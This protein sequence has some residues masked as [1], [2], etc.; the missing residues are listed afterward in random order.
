M[1]PLL[2][3]RSFS[4]YILP[5]LPFRRRQSSTASTP[6]LSNSPTSP[7]SASPPSPSY[8]H[9]ATNTIQC[10]RCRAD[11]A[12]TSQII[13]KGFTGRHGRA[14]LVAPPART[15]PFA[16]AP[17]A[18]ATD[19]PPGLPNTYEHRAVPRSLV[20]GA[21]V[22]S[23]IACARCH[24][25]LGWRYVAAEEPAQRYKVG[26]YIVETKRTTVGACWDRPAEK[27]GEVWGGEDDGSCGGGDEE[28]AFDSQDEEECDALFAGE[29]SGE[30]ARQRRARRAGG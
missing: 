22:V 28:A 16:P 5:P 12:Y 11:L 13:S 23:D 25:V 18:A 15:S 17:P 24:N 2:D 21:H 8:L 4:T 30:W 19:A 7:A 9:G 6:S 29:W 1:P 3:P 27:P 14:Y 20:T 10:S 26:K